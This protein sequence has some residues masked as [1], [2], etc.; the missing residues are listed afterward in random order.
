MSQDTPSLRGNGAS[1]A[2][3]QIPALVRKRTH[4]IFPIPP[5][6]SDSCFL[7]LAHY[8]T[9]LASAF[10]CDY[11]YILVATAKLQCFWLLR[12]GLAVDLETCYFTL[13]ASATG[14]E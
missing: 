14:V 4:A 11:F 9:R 8:Y 2:P 1:H 12:P 10:V 5:R 3:I 7:G 13:L 6:Q